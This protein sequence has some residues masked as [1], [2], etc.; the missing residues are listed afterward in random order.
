MSNQ[1][2][3]LPIL[4]KRGSLDSP[5]SEQSHIALFVDIDWALGYVALPDG[6]LCRSM[7]NAIIDEGRR[8]ASCRTCSASTLSPFSDMRLLEARP[9][10]LQLP[11]SVSFFELTTGSRHPPQCRALPDLRARSLTPRRSSSRDTV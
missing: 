5:L 2:E 6:Y 11:L 7:R 4:D 3:L 10:T 8:L 1:L 9:C